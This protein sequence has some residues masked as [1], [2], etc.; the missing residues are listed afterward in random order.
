[1]AK[2]K[3]KAKVWKSVRLSPVTV[4]QIEERAKQRGEAISKTIRRAV[5]R[6]LKESEKAKDK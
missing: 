3:E 5:T 6:G 1:M 4:T 2:R